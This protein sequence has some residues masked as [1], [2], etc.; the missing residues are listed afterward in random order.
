MKGGIFL[1]CHEINVKLEVNDKVEN[2][3][4][5]SSLNVSFNGS[6]KELQFLGA[7]ESP[8]TGDTMLAFS[9]LKEGQEL[10][11]G[12]HDIDALEEIY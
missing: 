12:L 6:Q 5:G 8:K 7:Y 2:I 1:E 9:D 3:L 11:V 10:I 4:W